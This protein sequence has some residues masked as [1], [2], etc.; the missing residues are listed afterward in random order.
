M[1]W[2]PQKLRTAQRALVEEALEYALSHGT[3]LP[4]GLF[5]KLRALL[6]SGAIKTGRMRHRARYLSLPL[7]GSWIELQPEALGLSALYD[8]RA[9]LAACS[10]CEEECASRQALVYAKA[11][12]SRL[13]VAAALVHEGTHA[14]LGLTLNRKQ[15]E[16]AAYLAESRFLTNVLAT[17]PH[18]LVRNAAEGLLSDVRR[19]A[20]QFEG[21]DFG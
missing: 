2:R 10:G 18:K 9:A 15:D 14:L 12:Q 13:F 16:R 17:Q 5:P 4:P 8:W 11:E 6:D 21:L 19:D 3:G 1:L 20:K 7:L